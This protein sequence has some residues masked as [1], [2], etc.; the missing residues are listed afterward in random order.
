M[1]QRPQCKALT[2]TPPSSSLAP[3]LPHSLAQPLRA[4]L[5]DQKP[6]SESPGPPKCRFLDPP[7]TA[8][9]KPLGR[10]LGICIIKG[11]LS[12]RV[13]GA[14][15]ALAHRCHSRLQRGLTSASITGLWQG[16]W[17]LSPVSPSAPQGQEFPYLLPITVGHTGGLNLFRKVR[18]I[19]PTA[20]GSCE[21]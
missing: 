19:L 10:G 1:Q 21:D 15:W 11:P 3:S 9:Q 13:T 8:K 4:C 6:S 5:W 16:A 7:R 14:S 20:Q 12:P 18:P 17:P 2:H